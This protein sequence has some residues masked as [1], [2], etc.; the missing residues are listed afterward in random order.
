MGSGLARSRRC[1]GYLSFNINVG[2]CCYDHMERKSVR[3]N[4]N[5]CKGNLSLSVGKSVGKKEK[6]LEGPDS[7]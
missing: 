3:L 2:E 4:A 5:E 6:G 7:Y 1:R